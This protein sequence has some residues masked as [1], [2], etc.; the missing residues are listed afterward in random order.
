MAVIKKFIK[1]DWVRLEGRS[2]HDSMV[3]EAQ[4]V[5]PINQSKRKPRCSADDTFIPTYRPAKVSPVG[6]R[7]I[8]YMRG[9]V[10][11]RIDAADRR[12]KPANR[13]RDIQL[14]GRVRLAGLVVTIISVT[15]PRPVNRV[16]NR[17]HLNIRLSPQRL[18]ELPECP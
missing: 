10:S 13:F 18:N 9:R 8:A 4:M 15:S 1:V 16:I 2:C 5:N 14:A 17:M 12:E 3:S 6:V 11:L 7:L